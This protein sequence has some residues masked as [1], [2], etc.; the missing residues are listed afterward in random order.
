MRESI[1][2]ESRRARGRHPPGDGTV[3]GSTAKDDPMIDQVRQVLASVRLNQFVGGGVAV[4]LRP[5]E[6]RRRLRRAGA[7]GSG[8]P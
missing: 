6:R 4:A 8:R 2:R 1:L 3:I 5:V 7:P